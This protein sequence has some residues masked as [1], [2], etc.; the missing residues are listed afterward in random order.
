MILIGLCGAKGSGKDTAADYL[1]TNYGY[2]RLAFADALKEEV[3]RIYQVPVSL[4][5]DRDL[6]EE[7]M[8]MLL[9]KS[10]RQVMQEYGV[11]K[12]E[13]DPYYW[14]DELRE[15]LDCTDY[16]VNDRYVITDVRFP[17]EV[18]YIR[19]YNN[20]Y[21]PRDADI[22]RVVRIMRSDIVLDDKH[23]SENALNH[24][25]FPEIRNVPGNPQTMWAQMDL[26]HNLMMEDM[27]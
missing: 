14:I 22:A 2:Q 7:P 16:G 3:A 8:P 24:F 15:V 18:E 1:V 21:T 12:R 17:N 27:R 6:K 9:G 26:L 23:T 10:P 13:Q 25:K 19:E 11:A 5:N 4:L 20:E